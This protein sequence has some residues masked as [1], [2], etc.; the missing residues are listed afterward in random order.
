MRLRHDSLRSKCQADHDVQLA[1]S[2]VPTHY[3][4]GVTPVV[5]VRAKT[6]RITDG[7]PGYYSTPSEMAGHDKRGFC[8]ECGSRL[9]G[10]ASEHSQGI[11]ASSLD[12]PSLFK[13]KVN[14]WTSDAQ[15]WDQ[16]DPNLPKFEKYPPS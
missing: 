11:A 2:R 16:M 13:P 6:F 1:L 5:Y 3:R 7:S 8:P 12:D 4:R 14:M 15:P 9:F 10:G